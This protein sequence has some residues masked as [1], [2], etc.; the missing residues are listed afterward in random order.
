MVNF[1]ERTV[2]DEL[3]DLVDV[4]VEAVDD[5]D[6]QNL[7]GFV[8]SLLHFKCFCIGSCSGLFAEDVLAC[9]QE[10]DRD[11]RVSHV[12][13]TDGN[14][15]DFRIVQNFVVVVDCLTAAVLFDSSVS[16]FGNDIAEILDFAGIICH[17]RGNVS[18]VC[19][20]TAADDGYLDL[21]VCHFGILLIKFL[22]LDYFKSI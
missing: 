16:A 10:V 14:C 18:S 13:G 5:T 19:N 12:G 15:F 1:T 4:F 21:F 6:V 20:R 17:V 11:G 2:S 3:A 8:L 7:T 9:A 22:N